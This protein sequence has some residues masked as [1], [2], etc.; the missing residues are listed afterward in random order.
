ME[1]PW[2]QYVFGEIRM[3]VLPKD[4]QRKWIL[5]KANEAASL[6]SL[7]RKK[8]LLLCTVDWAAGGVRSADSEDDRIAWKALFDQMY[9]LYNDHTTNGNQS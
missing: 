1:Y 4:E 7:K 9:K 8:G 2:F 6:S 5:R 3:L